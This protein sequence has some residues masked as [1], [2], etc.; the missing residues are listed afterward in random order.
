MTHLPKT[1]R[2]DFR[3]L[4]LLK[5]Y[6]QM[7]IERKRSSTP[8][9]P[10]TTSPVAPLPLIKELAQILFLQRIVYC[11]WKSNNALDKS[12]SGENDLDLLISRQDRT[13]FVQT[14]LMLGFIEV[15]D[16]PSSKM[17][18]VQDYIGYDADSGCLVHVHAHFQL[19]V[20]QDLAKNYHLPIEEPYLESANCSP[21]IK[22]QLFP[23]PSA[24]FELIVLVIRM[25]MK[26]AT[27]DSIIG[28]LGSPSKTIRTELETLVEE[29]D[30]NEV[31]ALLAMHLPSISFK[32]FERCLFALTPNA[33]KWK[34]IVAG[35]C[36]Q[37]QLDQATLRGNF[38]NLVLIQ[39]RRLVRAYRNH[40]VEV[41][42]RKTLS[43][44]GRLVAV[45]GG[46]GSGKTTSVDLLSSWLASDFTVKRVHLG[47][48]PWS[49]TTRCI[50][51]LLK[52]GRTLGLTPWVEFDS[53]RYVDQCKST[54]FPGYAMLIREVCTARDRYKDYIK[55][56]RSVSKGEIVICD[57]FP[58][59]ALKMMDGAQV[60]H[61][62]G[63]Y[64]NKR[65]VQYLHTIEQRY[66]AAMKHP[67]VLIVLRLDPAIA[68][69]RRPEDSPASVLMR[70][71]EIF[72]L[73]WNNIDA[74]VIDASLSRAEVD[75]N[76]RSIV[77][78]HLS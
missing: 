15:N 75:A 2:M 78:S 62:A 9:V 76:L 56:R 22:T 54:K 51:G 70:N 34:M 44:G 29:A 25:I 68:L 46:D 39:G 13:R 41:V 42:S 20:G 27:W 17:P 11:H 5:N 47:K 57:R 67:D 52:I 43:D 12:A 60:L 18:G 19:I 35:H 73:N 33:P 37:R 40:I 63:Q 30:M 77:W 49:N 14:L 50:R 4:A 45:V 28:R 31:R 74:N 7:Q 24:S 1:K 26:Y 23:V 71:A 53:V 48:P 16:S 61:L 32:L 3:Q 8:K 36:L 72:N 38:T 69:A 10:L 65:L 55:A 66:Y 6:D 64:Q 59:D 21:Q 58:L